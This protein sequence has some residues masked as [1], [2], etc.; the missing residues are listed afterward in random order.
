[1]HLPGKSIKYKP[2]YD[3]S[4]HKPYQANPQEGLYP[5]ELLML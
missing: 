1:M 2:D 4:K 5:E 3:F